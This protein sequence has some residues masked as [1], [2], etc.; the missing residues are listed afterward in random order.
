MFKNILMLALF[1]YKLIH[2]QPYNAIKLDKKINI[3]H[4]IFSYKIKI[5]LK[6]KCV[7]PHLAA[8]KLR[9]WFISFLMTLNFY[10]ENVRLPHVEA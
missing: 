1:Y 4:R 9:G 8:L 5:I 2:S 6:S 10:R 7:I 3:L